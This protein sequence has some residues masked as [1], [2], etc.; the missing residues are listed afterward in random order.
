MPPGGMVPGAP[1]TPWG[2]CE[3]V[4][5]GVTPLVVGRAGPE[6]PAL[7]GCAPDIVDDS[8]RSV[9]EWKHHQISE[10]ALKFVESRKE[11]L[12]RHRR[13][14]I[15]RPLSRVGMRTFQHASETGRASGM[16]GI[17]AA[18]AGFRPRSMLMCIDAWL[19]L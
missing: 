8:E 15:A 19:T 5:P 14:D 12:A 17:H 13:T 18:Y 16:Q 11:Y 2:C 3:A 10:E 9:G 4:M 1:G 6:G 7:L